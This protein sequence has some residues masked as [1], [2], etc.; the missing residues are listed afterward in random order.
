MDV[1][2]IS[3][4]SKDHRPPHV[5]WS[6]RVTYNSAWSLMAIQTTDIQHGLRLQQITQT[7]TEH[8]MVTKAMDSNTAFSCR[9]TTDP[10]TVLCGSTD[11]R[12]QYGFMWLQN[13]QTSVWLS[14]V[15]QVIHSR[16]PG[17]SRIMNS[18]MAFGSSTD[19]GCHCGCGSADNRHLN[20][21]QASTQPG[22]PT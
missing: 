3:G 14:M 21:P 7:S 9:R 19:Y 8:L 5:L 12:Y 11:Y 22:T 13:P 20:E 15:T 17:Y 10:D 1:Y 18:N 16:G 2:I 4:D 6:Q